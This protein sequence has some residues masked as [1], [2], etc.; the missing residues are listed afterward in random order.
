VSA[1]EK[2]RL[3]GPP[4]RFEAIEGHTQA[5]RAAREPDPNWLAGCLQRATVHGG[6]RVTLLKTML[7]SVCDRD[8]AY[9]AFRQ[10]RDFRRETFLP[11]ELA[12]LCKRLHDKGLVEGVFLSSGLRGSGTHTQD[13][14]IATAE[15]LRHKLGFRGYLHL[16]IM[17]GAER[18]QV[19]A[20]MALA[21]RVSVNLE[22]P[23]P[24]RLARLAPRKMFFKEL[25]QPI[26][27]IREIRSANPQ[28]WSSATTQF[29]VGAAGETDQEILSTTV[30]LYRQFSL[31]RVYYSR[32][33]PVAD[34]PFEGRDPCPRAREIRLYQ[35][36]FLLR[37]YGFD[38]D[39][40]I[41]GTSGN[42]PH[43]NDPKLLWARRH[44]KEAP[45]ELNRA[46]RTWLLRVP[47]IG[48]VTAQRLIAERKR[49]RLRSL[50][51]LAK[52]GVNTQRVAQFVLLDG[53][54]P[55]QQLSLWS[56]RG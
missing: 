14:L 34:T 1:I 31:A 7:S 13:R 54:R 55:A 38:I 28:P 43:S 37:D 19:R 20:A 4:T 41:F 18:E 15:V 12:Q 3:L 32:F 25:L 21:D 9:C 42:L 2:L 40:L 52:L 6:K 5:P 45:I 26:T 51:D 46:D 29:V 11:D 56:L 17:P 10:G 36:S 47:G 35:A 8:C 48:P 22:A 27:W 16:K 33:M 44:L 50:S 30:Y 49:G 23:S 24:G 53:R 39:D